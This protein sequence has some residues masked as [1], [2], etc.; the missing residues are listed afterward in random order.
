MENLDNKPNQLQVA[1][2]LIYDNRTVADG[3][4]HS[5]PDSVWRPY[6]PDTRAY[7]DS[8]AHAATRGAALDLAADEPARRAAI[9]RA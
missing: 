9:H 8:A 1:Y 2:H 5:S 7:R 3:T 6:I 4:L